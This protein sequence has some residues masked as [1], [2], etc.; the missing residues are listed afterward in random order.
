MK[1]AKIAQKNKGLF[2]NLVKST[3]LQRCAYFKIGLKYNPD[4][5]NKKALT[6]IK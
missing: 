1:Y 5:P 6:R 2:E 4:R 3:C